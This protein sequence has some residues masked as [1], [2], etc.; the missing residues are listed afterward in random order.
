MSRTTTGAIELP[1]PTDAV[2]R[3]PRDLDIGVVGYEM[4][5]ERTGVGRYL[6]GVLTGLAG[7]DDLDW[8][9]HLFFKGEPFE[10][11]LWAGGDP[12]FVPRFDRRATDR[13]ILWEQL[14]L[15]RLLRRQPLDVVFSPSYSLPPR[16]RAPALVTLHDLSFEHPGD[17]FPRKERYRRRFLA[18]RAARQAARVLA[19]T[20]AIASEL[21][22][23]Y[24]L[25]P[26]KIG[27]VPLAVD[28]RFRPPPAGTD[29]PP[30]LHALGVRPPYLLALG[31]VLARRHLDVV[32]DTVARLAPPHD[33]HQ[34]VIAGRNR[35]R[36]PEDLRTWIER[37]G[38][39][40]RVL[41][42]GYVDEAVLPALYGHATASFYLSSYEG[43]GLPPLESLAA[44]TPAIVAP[45]LGL[46]DLWP[47]YPYRCPSIDRSSVLDICHRLLENGAHRDDV[48]RE[49]A[50]RMAR[51]DWQHTAARFVDQ[52]C[53]SRQ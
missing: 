32:L 21:A 9:W 20:G 13:P 30:S 39:G 15:P 27:V 43:F 37:S 49:G 26:S 42:L 33:R 2:A 7:L 23:R 40:D 51:L 1:A 8:R 36:R 16:L 53:R 25:P 18:R 17:A 48:A 38:L 3:A 29:L 34:L 11:P 24:R 14:R 10:H 35:L 12:R 22:E 52:V 47:A 44:G 6:E 41:R 31:T 4:E 5:G 19:D 28:R 50:E 45:G 46:D